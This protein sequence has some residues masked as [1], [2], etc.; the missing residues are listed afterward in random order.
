MA[1]P[2]G[3]YRYAADAGLAARAR[4]VDPDVSDD[5]PSE[6]AELDLKPGT[7]VTVTGYDRDRDLV[8]VGWTD[9]QGTPRITSVEPGHFAATFA[10][11]T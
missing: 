8:L 2:K 1:V 11:V 9:A 3:T 7:G 6:M 10:K 4:V 5:L